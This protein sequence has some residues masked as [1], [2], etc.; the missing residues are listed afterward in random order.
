M[1]AD[2]I[3]VCSNTLTLTIENMGTFTKKGRQTEKRE[4]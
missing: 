2:T 4:R 3:D 1:G